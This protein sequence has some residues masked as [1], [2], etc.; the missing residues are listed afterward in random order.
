MLGK[1]DGTFASP[2][3]YAVG[4]NPLA[5]LAGDLNG[6]GRIDLTI[7]NQ[8]GILESP[9]SVSV[10]LGKGDGTFRPGVTYNLNE[11]PM[12][13]AAGDFNGDGHLDLAM[14]DEDYYDRSGVTLIY[15]TTLLLG[16]GD[17]TFAEVTV[18]SQNHDFGTAIAA[19]D[20]IGDGHLDLAIVELISSSVSV[21]LGNGDGT[22]TD[23][24]QLATT[25]YAAPLEAD[26]NGDGTADVLVVDSA[27]NILYRQGIPGQPG[28]FLPPVT[29]NPGNLSRDIAWL[30]N[31][32]GGPV[33]ASVD[34][35]GD[36][37]SFYAYRDGGFVRLGGRWRPGSSRR[38]HRGSAQWRRPGRPC[39]PQCR[40]RDA[41][42]VLR[43]R[44]AQRIRRRH[45]HARSAGLHRGRQASGRPGRF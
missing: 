39:R 30:P 1:G 24:D 25:R 28:S 9:G 45:H 32:S 3:T 13:V 14:T 20:F 19:A 27:G 16:K 35:Q 10:L 2:V 21:T 23:P 42:G 33:L 44:I 26:V 41:H 15:S 40:R 5:I 22:F 38:D 29:V 18:T 6:D 11:N 8:G 4:M 43:Y 37:I 36:A 34:A 7:V 12:G 17:G 31:T